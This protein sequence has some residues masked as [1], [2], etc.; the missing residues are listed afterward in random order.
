M[1]PTLREAHFRFG[2]SVLL[3]V[4]MMTFVYFGGVFFALA[5]DNGNDDFALAC[6]MNPSAIRFSVEFRN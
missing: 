3:P 1:A 4:T 2:F 5:F 6:T